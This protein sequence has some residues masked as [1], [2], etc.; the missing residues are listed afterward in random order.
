MGLHPIGH[1]LRRQFEAEHARIAI[2]AAKRDRAQPAVEGA[3]A[4][5]AAKVSANRFPGSRDRIVMT[6]ADARPG[7]HLHHAKT[8]SLSFAAPS[9]RFCQAQD[10]PVRRIAPG[11]PLSEPRSPV[12]VRPGFARPEILFWKPGAARSRVKICHNEIIALD[13]QKAAELRA[14]FIYFVF[15]QLLEESTRD[16]PAKNGGIPRSPCDSHPDA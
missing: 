8:P 7:R 10:C 6:G 16:W 4:A 14:A 1:E 9:R 11:A 15:S 3:R 13:R 5:I 2:E 12:C